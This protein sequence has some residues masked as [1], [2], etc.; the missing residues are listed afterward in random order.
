MCIYGFGNILL[1]AMKQN[2]KLVHRDIMTTVIYDIVSICFEACSK[3]LMY[4]INIM[5]NIIFMR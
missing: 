1:K 2:L 5:T 3:G 4:L